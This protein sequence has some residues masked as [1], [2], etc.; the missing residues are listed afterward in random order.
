MYYAEP[1]RIVGNDFR[2]FE[3]RLLNY[4]I[5]GSAADVCKE[6]L[7]RYDRAREHG[8]M[9]VTVHDEINISVPVAHLGS[10]SAV[11]KAAMESVEFDVPMLTEG[12]SGPSWGEIR[13]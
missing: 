7:I 10:E 1:P 4:L 5:Q 2:S 3:Y 12:K 9:L 11:L 8:R 13:A 6:A